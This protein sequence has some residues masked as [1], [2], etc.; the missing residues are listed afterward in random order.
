MSVLLFLLLLPLLLLQL[1]FRLLL[2]PLLDMPAP[3]GRVQHDIFSEQ[4]WGRS[5]WPA[6]RAPAWRGEPSSAD[7]MIDDIVLTV[8]RQS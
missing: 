3:A 4:K 7:E 5:G 2:L 1:V 6:V 8:L